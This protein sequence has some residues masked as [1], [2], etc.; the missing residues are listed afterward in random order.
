MVIRD[1]LKD[2][3]YFDESVEF[4]LEWIDDRR[5]GLKSKEKLPPYRKMLHAFRI[6]NNLLELMH[7]R[8][9]RGDDIA[10]MRED[11]CLTLEYREWQ[12]HYADA[13]SEDEQ[14]KRVG[15]EEL[16]E[17]YMEQ[18]LKWFAFAYCV[19]MGDSYY[20]KMLDLTGNK[21]LDI[22][23]D[24]IAVKLGDT[25]RPIGGKL[26]YPKRFKPLY[27]VIDAEPAQRPELMKAYLDAWYDLI[28]RPDYHLMDTDAY[29]GYWCWEAALV[30]KLYD[31]DDSSFSD[32][33]YY[34][35]DLVHYKES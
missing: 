14:S 19:G 30:V 11:L 29:D 15:R 26:L 28:G 4:R 17:D 32:H 10:A 33:P 25:E 13:L 24:S 12:K 16:R 31:I 2:K 18:F 1:T 7:A 27:Q 20:R 34:P 9:S 23:F 6:V 35:V 3:A 22:L 5:N 21:G 8:Y